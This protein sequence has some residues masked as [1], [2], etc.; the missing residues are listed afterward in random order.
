MY[1]ASLAE[2]HAKGDADSENPDSP[3][4]GLHA[5]MGWNKLPIV[6]SVEKGLT[7]VQVKAL[8]AAMTIWETAVGKQLFSFNPS[9]NPSGSSFPDLYSTLND[10]F[11]GHYDVLNWKK[12]GKRAEVIATAV[13][14]NQGSDY[15]IISAADI[16]YN[17]E[18]YYIS[19]ALIH[20]QVDHRE[21]VDMT[22]LAIHELGHLLGLAHVDEAYDRSS[23]MNPSLYIGAGLATRSLSIGDITRIQQIYGCEGK[24]CDKENTALSIMMAEK[25]T[26]ASSKTAH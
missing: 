9:P 22:S 11:N 15:R 19:D 16:E 24:A 17:S 10:G 4:F 7:E 8:Q 13:W 14:S 3:E 2:D 26:K 5:P 12:T 18:L 20:K 25:A 6:Y 1:K 23:V 21:I